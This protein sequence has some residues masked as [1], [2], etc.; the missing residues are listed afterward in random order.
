MITCENLGYP[1]FIYKYIAM[2]II[3]TTREA[4]KYSF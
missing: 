1:N 4:I 2:Q 3:S